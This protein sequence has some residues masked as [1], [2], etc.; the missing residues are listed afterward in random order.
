MR[1]LYVSSDFGIALDGVKGAS[2]HVRAITR[3]LAQ[4]GHEV[5]VLAPR[6]ILPAEH[7]AQKLEMSPCKMA[8]EVHHSIRG[9]LQDR[10]LDES[11]ARE[12]RPLIYNATVLPQVVDALSMQPP[13]AVIERLSL[14]GHLGLDLARKFNVPFVVEMNAPLTQEASAYRSLNMQTLAGDIEHR[15]LSAADGVAVVS[16]ALALR[17]RQWGKESGKIRV[18]PNG[19]D[20]QEFAGLGPRA[21]YRPAE[22]PSGSFVVGFAGS[23][24]PWHGVSVLV[25]AFA[26]IA[27]RD[28]GARLVIVGTGPFENEIRN[29][30]ANRGLG[31]RVVMAGA[32]PHGDVPRWLRAMDVAVAPF[33]P[34]DDFYFSPIKIFEYMASGTCVVASELGQIA[35]VIK[36]G[37]NG[38]LCKPG[39]VD[40]LAAALDR[41]RSDPDLRHSMERR[42][43]DDVRARFTW[44]HAAESVEELVQ[45]ASREPH[46]VATCTRAAHLPSVVT[47]CV[48]GNAS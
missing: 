11:V 31:D 13:E 22:I 26:K 4:R 43:Q 14:F 19:V 20:L 38:V 33:L 5:T 1:L 39:D 27:S 40:D 6:G 24:K 23:L 36:G 25:A 18:V 47:S 16:S 45:A 12:L 44:S 7:P 10:E 34:T 46:L 28:A 35:D 32:V 3:A 30:V 29:E 37:V 9:W 8:E 42:A 21:S 41:L 17:L 48:S 2:V 15:I